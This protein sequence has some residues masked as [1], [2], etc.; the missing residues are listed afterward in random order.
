MIL[1]SRV[2]FVYRYELSCMD[3]LIYCCEAWHAV[4]RLMKTLDDFLQCSFSTRD[5]HAS[6]IPLGSFER[7]KIAFFSFYFKKVYLLKSRLVV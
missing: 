4:C 2:F 5:R 7:G 1:R 3:K 6:D